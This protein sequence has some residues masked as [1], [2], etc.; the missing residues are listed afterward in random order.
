MFNSK[1][2][3]FCNFSFDK[4]TY[5]NVFFKGENLE[6]KRV[7][8]QYKPTVQYLSY[9]PALLLSPSLTP[10]QNQTI[11]LQCI[12]KYL[13]QVSKTKGGGGESRNENSK[14]ITQKSKIIDFKYK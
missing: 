6:N 10:F 7:T 13:V 3:E 14:I 4:L 8:D 1:L 12:R 2:G 9:L 11:K 5:S